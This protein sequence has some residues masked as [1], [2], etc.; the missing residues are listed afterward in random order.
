MSHIDD[1]GAVPVSPGGDRGDAALDA[2]FAAANAGMVAAIR[3]GFDLDA[4]LAR[5]IGA[6]PQVEI[7]SPGSPAGNNWERLLSPC[8]GRTLAGHGSIHTFARLMSV[9]KSHACGFAFW[10]SCGGVR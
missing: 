1:E 5:I 4:G 3:R 9:L 6:P 7:R 8:P 2:A 10:S